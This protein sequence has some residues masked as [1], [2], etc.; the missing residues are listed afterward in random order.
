MA[1]NGKFVYIYICV[2]VCVGVGV[3]VSVGVGGWVHACMRACVRVCVC[4]RV[5]FVSFVLFD[6]YQFNSQRMDQSDQRNA[7][8]D[9]RFVK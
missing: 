4:M 7:A 8:R 5:L 9:S 2:C 3:S 1:F 6:S